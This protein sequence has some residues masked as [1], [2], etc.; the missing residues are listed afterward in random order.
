MRSV[1]IY[2]PDGYSELPVR[3]AM[4]AFHPFNP[5]RW[6]ASSWC[7]T[8]R[9]FA[10]STGLLLICPDG[11]PG[12]NVLDEERDTLLA[13][14]A[15]DIYLDSF[16]VTAGRVYVGGF[17][18]GGAA[19]YVYG[20]ANPERIAGFLVVGAAV[21]GTTLFGE[22]LSNAVDRPFCI[23]HGSADAPNV[24]FT[25]VIEALETERAILFDTLLAGVGHTIDFPNRN[26]LLADCFRRMDQVVGDG[27]SSV[28]V[29]RSWDGVN[30]STVRRYVVSGDRILLESASTN[31]KR[32]MAIGVRLTDGAGRTVVL[33][34]NRVS[35]T[36]VSIAT[37][38]LDPG[39]WIAWGTEREHP[40]AI[41]LVTR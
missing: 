27:M 31:E 23:L 7:D 41:L 30:R 35:S 14:M 34:G 9:S 10:D 22:T 16:D 17:S 20:L 26:G 25:P 39:L 38:T 40:T 37:E 6:S 28:D 12:G 21:N 4:L 24:R 33:E 15:L 8:L 3:R 32:S 5:A 1:V 11:G 29:G 36:E 13:S 19:S 2:E 18:M